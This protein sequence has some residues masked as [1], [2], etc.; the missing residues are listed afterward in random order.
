MPANKL[1][2]YVPRCYLRSFCIDDT[3]AAINL[4]NIAREVAIPRAP[5]KN[6][7]ARPYFYGK[8]GEL[9]KAL[10]E[11]EGLYAECLRK[12]VAD[13]IKLSPDDLFGLRTFMLLQAFRSAAWVDK[14]RTQLEA[15]REMF[16][17]EATPELLKQLTMTEIEIV[18]MA[19]KMF[20]SCLPTIGDLDTCV[21][22]NKTAREFI[23]S[24]DPVVHTNRYHAQKRFLGG[25]GLRNSGTMLFMPMTPRLLLV[26]F[27]PFVYKLEGRIGHV[28]PIADIREIDNLNQMQV[29]HAD[30]NLY[31]SSWAQKAFVSTAF[32]RGRGGR[33]DHWFKLEILRETASNSGTFVPVT[34]HFEHD[35][36]RREVLHVEQILPKP[37]RWPKLLPFKLRPKV[38]DTKSGAGLERPIAP[39]GNAQ[40]HT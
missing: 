40:S 21:L 13:P 29:V 16:R 32:N 17:E 35:P 11:P 27:D 38:I 5:A 28:A 10:Q 23:S 24:D 26:A 15:Q 37:D 2:H 18:E 20:T 12:A 33:R 31:F 39:L 3:G 22:V 30:S 8:D 25:S 7:C 19:F 36:E 9:E 1:Q 14:Q 6:Q 4:F 34:T